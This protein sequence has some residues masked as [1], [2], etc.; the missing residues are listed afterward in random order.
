MLL[1]N[2][3]RYFFGRFCTEEL[4]HFSPSDHQHCE[5]CSRRQDPAYR[6]DKEESRD[7]MKSIHREENKYPEDSCTAGSDQINQHRCQGVTET[8]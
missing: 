8:A 3:F 7:R 4:V 1:R 6:V 2:G 5:V